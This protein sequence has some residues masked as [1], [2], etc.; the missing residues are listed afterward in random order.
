MFPEMFPV[1]PSTKINPIET[2]INTFANRADPD[3]RAVWSA[4]TVC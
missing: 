2:P 3:V 1:M 4:S